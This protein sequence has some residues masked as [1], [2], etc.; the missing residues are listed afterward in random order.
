[1]SKFPLF[2]KGLMEGILVI[3]TKCLVHFGIRLY[4]AD[5]A[6]FTSAVVGFASLMGIFLNN[7]GGEI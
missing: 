2:F 6:L 3:N 7:L 5:L 4:L 1:M